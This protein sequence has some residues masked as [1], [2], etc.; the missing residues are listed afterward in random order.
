MTGETLADGSQLSWTY[1][2]IS[3]YGGAYD[4]VTESIDEL[5]HQTWYTNDSATGD[6]LAV[7]QVLGWARYAQIDPITQYTYT[8]APTSQSEPP[9]GLVA[10]EIDPLG[11]V[12]PHGHTTDYDYNAHGL[13]TTTTYPDGLQTFNVYDSSD[14]LLRQIDRSGCVTTYTYDHLG[15]ETSVTEP[16][17]GTG[18]ETGSSPMLNYAYDP[19]GNVVEE[20]DGFNNT[21]HYGYDACDRLTSETDADGKTTSYTYDGAGDL[22]TETDPMENETTYG[23]RPAEHVLDAVVA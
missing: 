21:I 19:D 17:P 1:Q 9:G 2:T 7:E 18:L 11:Y 6:V 5:G 20:A 12:N 14:N 23:K 3:S 10:T 8:P 15:R 13:L 4:A 16:D 22:L